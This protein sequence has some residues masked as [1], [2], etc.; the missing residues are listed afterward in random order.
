MCHLKYVLSC[1][2]HFSYFDLDQIS[3]GVLYYYY[4]HYYYWIFKSFEFLRR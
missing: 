4:Y 1:E 3:E 2:Q